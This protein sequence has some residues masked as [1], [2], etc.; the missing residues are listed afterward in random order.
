M[1][2]LISIVD[3]NTQHRQTLAEALKS[4]YAVQAY[5]TPVNALAGMNIN[6]PRVI[7]VGQKVGAGSGV[8]FIRD[9][10]KEQFLGE[11]PVIFVIDNED[12][13]IVEQMRETAIKDYLVKPY[14]R[15]SLFGAITKHINKSVEQSWAALPST[16]R[17]ALEDSLRAFNSIAEQIAA[18]K[19]LPFDSVTEPCSAIVDVVAKNEIGPMMHRIK[20]HDNFTYVHSLRFAT[21]MS[22]FGK[23]IGLPKDQQILIASGGMLHDIGKM[24]I[25]RDLLTKQGALSPADWKVLRGH[26]ATSV[27]LLATN[28]NIP[29]GVMSMVGNHHERIDGSGYPRALPGSE[30][31]RLGRMA[32]IIDVFCALTD[33]KPYKRTVPAHAALETMAT[34]MKTQLDQTLLHTFKEILL[35]T[36]PVDAPAD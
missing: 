24:T 36:V 17:K 16:Q 20:A 4:N 27:K 14:P 23:A 35:E 3:A 22:L 29:K 34:E 11:I 2:H 21:L 32:G 12:F 9:L 5:D 10:R 1:Q 13:R 33:R 19:P 15:S 30:I 28:E 7:L 6:R 25:P 8:N 18:G 26:V 31:N